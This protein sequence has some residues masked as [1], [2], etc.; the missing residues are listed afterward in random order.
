MLKTKI[1]FIPLLIAIIITSL[2]CTEKE[3][4]LTWPKVERETRPGVYWWWMG[5]AV[6]KG[7]L[8]YNLEMLN[9]AGIGGVTVVPIYGVKGY[10]NRFINYLTPQWMDMLEYTLNETNRLNMWVDMTTG[11]GW[12]FGGSHVTPE[13]AAKKVVHKVYSLSKGERL[14]EK[15][16]TTNLLA[17]MAYSDVKGHIELTDKVDVNGEL[18]WIAPAG[19]WEI[20]VVWMKGT[21]QQVKRAAPGNKGLVIDPFSKE[22]LSFY[23]ERFNIAFSS[24]DIK[25]LR[26]QYHDSFE[27]YNADWTKNFFEE[28]EKRQGYDLRKFLPLLFS[29][30]KSDNALHIK[31]DF[32]QTIAELHLEYIRAWVNWSHEKDCLTRDQ[33][34][35]APGNLL[36]LYAAADIPETETFGSTPFNIPGLRRK[37]ENVRQDFPNPLVLRFSSSAAHVAGKHLVASE[38][39]TWLREHFKVSLSQVKPEVDQLFLSGIN[40]IFYHGNAYSP[41]EAPWP[42]WLF[43]A[44]TIFQPVNSIWKDFPSLNKYVTRC[45]S[46]L[47]KGKPDNDILI[48][49]PIFDI[50][51]QKNSMVRGLNVHNLDWL[52][53][54][55]FEKVASTLLK[56]GFAFDY[57][58]DNQLKET[59]CTNGKLRISNLEYKTIIL[60]RTQFIPLTTLQKLLDLVNEGATVIIQ[61]RLPANISGLNKLEEKREEFRKIIA[62]LKFNKIELSNIKLTEYGKGRLLLG[63]DLPAM[64]NEAKVKHEAIA[65]KGTGFIRRKTEDG[66]H[67]FFANL[68]NRIIDGWIPL[69]V[70]CKS[71]AI[72]D[73]L[74][75][76]TGVAGFRS[77]GDVSEI[78][79]QL[80]PGQSLIV[81]T[82]NDKEITGKVWQYQLNEGEPLEITGKWKVEFIDGGSKLPEAFTTTK[83]KS[84]T[85][86]GDTEAKRFAG[87]ARYSIEFELPQNKSDD[88]L[89]DISNV[90][91]SARIKINGKMVG[92]VWSIPFEIPVGQFLHVGKNKMEIEVTNLSANRIRDLDKRGVDWKKFYDINFVDINYNKFDAS[93]WQLE[94]SGLL[95]PV[96]IFPQK[97]IQGKDKNLIQ[98]NDSLKAKC[99]KI[100][101]DELDDEENFWVSI[102]AAEAL[103]L[104]GKSSDVK[105]ILEKRLKR[106]KDGKKLCGIA[107]ELVRAGD[108]SKAKV[109]LNILKDKNYT[110]A[111]VHACESLYKVNQI[112]DGK[113]LLEAMN[114]K[115]N[116]NKRLFAAA[117][118]GRHGNTDAMKIIRENLNSDDPE[119]SSRAAWMLARIGDSSDIPNLKKAMIRFRDEK[120]VYE[121]ENAL[122]MLGD[123]DGLKYLVKNLKSNEPGIR[124]EAATFAG[125]IGSLRYWDELIKFLDDPNIGVRVRAAQ[126]ILRF[127]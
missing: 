35:G 10:E 24:R 25:S 38:T 9:Q 94:D 65:K 42:G 100:L 26:A 62:K 46:F 71:A 3:E 23:L 21:G 27:Y 56:Q 19:K 102:H 28:F 16:D 67:Y 108:K 117:A 31:M 63:S 15:I 29:D 101:Y 124:E 7:N 103:I 70:Q 76:K 33:A 86:L 79:L 73:P 75:E 115:E 114:Q 36:D 61:D 34:H 49:W 20:Y 96:R 47:Q 37:P 80:N 39:C 125:E 112:G 78:Y 17:V 12:P 66:Y 90:R 68:G 109:M 93:K 14:K 40:H 111:H 121:F 77:N 85:E 11:T 106:E 92:V 74:T 84:W 95:A 60:P 50:W 54:T 57:I 6:D 44:S 116:K 30:E 69:S 126:S 32:R 8:T 118:L 89:L 119:F 97:I 110:Y 4:N 123:K 43:Y 58:S 52:Q 122:A 41:K 45:Q 55:P 64:L 98:A 87:T 48:Y 104:A 81:K 59:K 22:A 113:L 2:S 105:D 72:F 53:N 120:G 82:F 88:W 13:Y 83:L 99:Y 18:N 5:S 107:R 91:E 127:E 51:S 1:T